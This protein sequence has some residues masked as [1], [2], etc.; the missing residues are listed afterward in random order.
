[1]L[2]KGVLCVFINILE[3]VDDFQ[4]LSTTYGLIFF[5]NLLTK[6]QC[7]LG[8][9]QR[10]NQYWISRIENL[11][12]KGGQECKFLK[13]AKSIYFPT[14]LPWPLTHGIEKLIYSG[15]YD[16]IITNMSANFENIQPSAL[17]IIAFTPY[18]RRGMGR[19]WRRTGVLDVN[20]SFPWS[21]VLNNY[22]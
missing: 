10:R 9:H 12:V 2:A 20:P 11:A 1:M 13:W 14:L 16:L 17:W 19:G 7:L 22:K 15:H 21:H 4:I 8:F 18:M 3:W 6:Q 5:F